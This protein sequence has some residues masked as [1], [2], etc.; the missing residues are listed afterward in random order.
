MLGQEGRHTTRSAPDVSDTTGGPIPDQL[1]ERRE[2]RA[3]DG[4]LGR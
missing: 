3:V 4:L 1:D 2:Q